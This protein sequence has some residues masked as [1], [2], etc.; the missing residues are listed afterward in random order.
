MRSNPWKC[1]M[2]PSLRLRLGATGLR[3][4]EALSLDRPATQPNQPG[5]TSTPQSPLDAA[6]ATLGEPLA[7]WANINQRTSVPQQGPPLYTPPPALTRR[8]WTGA[9]T[10]V[11]HSTSSSPAGRKRTTNN[12]TSP[13]AAVSMKSGQEEETADSTSRG[14]ALGPRPGAV[15][16]GDLGNTRI[17]DQPA[18][19]VTTRARGRTVTGCTRCSLRL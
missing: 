18:R 19:T 11:T 10:P 6:P 9:A 13:G 1:R 8:P 4:Y 16:S 5:T 2:K 17:R 14:S 3:H 12:H 15:E 7:C